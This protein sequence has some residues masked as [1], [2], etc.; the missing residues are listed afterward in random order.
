MKLSAMFDQ[1]P[2]HTFDKIV[3]RIIATKNTPRLTL[4]PQFK[5]IAEI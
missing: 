4:S 5:T 1:N 2:P 3:E